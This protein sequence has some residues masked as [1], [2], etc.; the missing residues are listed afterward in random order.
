M[1]DSPKNWILFLKSDDGSKNPSEIIQISLAKLNELREKYLNNEVEEVEYLNQ[2]QEIVDQ[3]RLRI[4]SWENRR[5][6]PVK[7]LLSLFAYAFSPFKIPYFLKISE[8]DWKFKYE[9]NTFKESIRQANE[10][11]LKGL[12]GKKLAGMA[13]LYA[14][15]KERFNDDRKRELI[16]TQLI[17]DWQEY[18]KTPA[19]L[20]SPFMDEFERDIKNGASFKRIDPVL[21]IED[22]EPLP[23][24]YLDSKKR[25]EE[26]LALLQELLKKTED[27]K[28]NSILQFSVTHATLITAFRLPLSTYNIE[29]SKVQWESEG[30]YDSI[31]SV[32]SKNSP[33]VVVEVIRSPQNGL[34]EKVKVIVKG[35]IDI[36]S[37]HPGEKEADQKTIAPD[38]LKIELKYAI[39]FDEKNQPLIQELQTQ[40]ITKIAI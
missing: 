17:L 36:V 19:I 11:N 24:P 14:Q 23:P 1:N 8:E 16:N 18:E 25:V 31:K 35:S 4:T 7:Q 27:Q 13:P 5:N 20:R 33:P 34:I 12:V 22:H 2:T 6:H 26:A 29:A 37:Y 3:T 30:K 39:I 21:N 38:A 32:F 40:M 28:W 15:L 10:R 9:M